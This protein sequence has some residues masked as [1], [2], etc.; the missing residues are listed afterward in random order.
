MANQSHQRYL[1]LK[2]RHSPF[3]FALTGMAITLAFGLFLQ[4]RL[5]I[6]AAAIVFFLIYLGMMAKRIPRMSSAK[7]KAS[8]ERDDEPAPVI[9]FITLFAVIAAVIALFNALNR[10]HN[11]SNVEVGLAFV[12]VILGWLTIHTM[13]AAHY[14]H[15]FWRHRQGPDGL[16]QD[17]GLEFPQTAEPDGTDFLYFSF[18][19]GMTAQTSDVAITTS[20]MRRMNLAHA[21]VSF[22]FNTVLVAAAVNTVLSLAG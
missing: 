14:A 18:V 15:R 5:A 22:F 9:L 4:P 11:P 6:E 20:S 12:S 7:L 8:P 1:R 19:I 3:Y 13:F 10:A 17:K 2:R 21:V 16:Q